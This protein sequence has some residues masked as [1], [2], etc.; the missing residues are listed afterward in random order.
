ME[1]RTWYLVSRVLQTPVTSIM[2][3]RNGIIALEDMAAVMADGGCVLWISGRGK[4]YLEGMG[5]WISH[6]RRAGEV[7]SYR[8]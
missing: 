6:D 3:T 5:L 2:P 4:V 8:G 7:V 1:G